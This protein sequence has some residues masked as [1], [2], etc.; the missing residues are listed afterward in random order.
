[1]SKHPPLPKLDVRKVSEWDQHNLPRWIDEHYDVSDA[2]PQDLLQVSRLYGGRWPYRTNCVFGSQSHF[3]GTL[4]AVQQ[5]KMDDAEASIVEDKRQRDKKPVK[6]S[7]SERREHRTPTAPRRKVP[8]ED[9]H[10]SQTPTSPVSHFLG[11]LI[12][13]EHPRD[14]ASAG[15]EADHEGHLDEAFIIYDQ[16]PVAVAVSPVILSRTGAVR[17]AATSPMTMPRIAPRVVQKK[18]IV[19]ERCCCQPDLSFHELV[20]MIVPVLS[21]IA[22]TYYRLIYG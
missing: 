10:A 19:R 1:M 14:R 21:V 2:S 16:S 4:S 3:R 11:H 22:Y 13:P 7:T 8:H 17:D 15:T 18:V 9:L 6:P 20:V 5:K 12:S